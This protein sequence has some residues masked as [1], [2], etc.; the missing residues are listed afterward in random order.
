MWGGGR[1]GEDL[2]N[3]GVACSVRMMA[4]ENETREEVRTTQDA[5]VVPGR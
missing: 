1:Y 3:F 2:S 5:T 4:F